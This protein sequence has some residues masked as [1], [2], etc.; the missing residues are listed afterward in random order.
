VIKGFFKQHRDAMVGFLRTHSS[1]K[2]SRGKF[3]VTAVGQPEELKIEDSSPVTGKIPQRLTVA[4]QG[5]LVSPGITTGSQP[6]EEEATAP[7]ALSLHFHPSAALVPKFL[8]N[9][10]NKQAAEKYSG[11]HD[12][13]SSKW[14]PGNCLGQGTYGRVC[15]QGSP[16]KPGHA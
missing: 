4:P 11:L 2:K 8:C 6:A 3:V 10:N 14:E 16:H 1:Y 5:K 15:H 9:L 12:A 13:T 7:P